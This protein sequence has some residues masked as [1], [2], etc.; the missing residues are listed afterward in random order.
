MTLTQACAQLGLSDK[1]VLH[2]LENKVLSAHA[3]SD[4]SKSVSGRPILIEAQ[5]VNQLQALRSKRLNLAQVALLLGIHNRRVV[6]LVNAGLLGADRERDI[7]PIRYWSFAYDDI[8][9]FLQRIV[10]RY[11]ILSSSPAPSPS[12]AQDIQT[13]NQALRRAYARQLTLSDLILGI[14]AGKQLVFQSQY[15][16]ATSLKNLRFTR[17]ALLDFID[18]RC[19]DT[20]MLLSVEQVCRI[21]RCATPALRCLRQAGMLQPLCEETSQTCARWLYDGR[22]VKAFMERYIETNAAVALLEIR[23]HTLKH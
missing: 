15:V 11:P 7:D 4:L 13:F 23:P 5:S 22:D 6:E 14:E 19:L 12:N 9:E 18:Q 16:G 2:L 17:S 3:S 1:K 10:R 21:L 8:D 20:G